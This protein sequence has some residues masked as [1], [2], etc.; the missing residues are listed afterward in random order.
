[1]RLL[2]TCQWQ[3]RLQSYMRVTNRTR[4]Q[5]NFV[6]S[7]IISHCVFR[8]YHFQ[9]WAVLPEGLDAF[10]AFQITIEPIS[11]N[12]TELNWRD[13]MHGCFDSFTYSDQHAMH[14]AHW[15]SFCKRLLRLLCKATKWDCFSNALHRTACKNIDFTVYEEMDIF[16]F[17]EK[18]MLSTEKWSGFEFILTMNVSSYSWNQS[19]LFLGI[20]EM[21]QMNL[22]QILNTKSMRNITIFSSFEWRENFFSEKIEFEVWI[23]QR[24]C[25]SEF[26][27]RNRLQCPKYG[28]RWYFYY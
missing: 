18:L 9:F 5:F 3:C 21:E 12:S 10:Y 7:F 1:M 6:P 24:S 27:I 23:H 22:Q 14:I 13:K 20:F 4:Q 15:Y 8:H 2:S 26:M 25:N 19:L 17:G 28:S 11:L 16:D